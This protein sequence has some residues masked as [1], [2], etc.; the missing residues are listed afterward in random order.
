MQITTKELKTYLNE[1][2]TNY[3]NNGLTLKDLK[4]S[5]TLENLEQDIK[6][7]LNK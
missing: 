1:L 5:I 2:L 4:D 6:I 3:D 7:T